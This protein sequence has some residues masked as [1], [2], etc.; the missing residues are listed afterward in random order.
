MVVPSPAN[1]PVHRVSII[2]CVRTFTYTVNVHTFFVH[3]YMV[4]LS[5]AMQIYILVHATMY[6]WH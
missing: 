1:F 2:P 3:V 6:T 5:T 4:D